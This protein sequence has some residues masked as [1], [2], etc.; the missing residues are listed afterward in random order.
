MTLRAVLVLVVAGCLAAAPAGAGSQPVRA[1]EGMVVAQ[2]AR[3][4]Q[5]GADVLRDGG[6]AV[7][8]AVATAFALA[9]T[10]PAA[11]NVGGGGF[12]LYRP[13]AG[14]PAAYDFREKAPAGATATMFLKDGRYDAERHHESHLSVG[15]PGT[16]AGLHMAW[17]EHGRLP[18]RRL[19]E[20][21]VA[22]ARDGFAVTDG[23][24]R[25]LKDV[26]PKMKKYPASVAQ[27][28][29]DGSPYAMGD[30]LKQPDLALTLERIA[31]R[32]P[33]GFYEGETAELVEKEMAAHG[34]LITR[35]DLRAY[36]A[37]RRDPLKG[38]YRGY[39]V[40]SMP[41][42][43]SGGTALIEM[44][45]V[46]EGYD[47]ARTGYGSA[48]TVHLL[49]EAMR[50][51]FA[52]RA[53][54][55]GDP[56]ANPQMPIDRLISKEYAATLRRTIHEDRAS[57]S[58]PE[59][60]EWP[61][62][63]AET[64]HVSVVDR[65]RNA[66]ALTYTLEDGYGSKI[67]V[68]GAGFLLN[69][70]MGDFN[71][72]PGLTDKDGLIGTEP[73]LAAPGKR[74]LSS[75]TPTIVARDGGL[76]M[77]VGT[78]GGRTIINT[79]LQALVNVID[80]GMNIQEAIDAPRL[81]HQWLPDRIQHERFGLSPDTRALLQAR[82]HTLFEAPFNQ[83]AA[84]GIVVNS[85]EGVLEGGYD[86]RSSESAAIGSAVEVRSALLAARP[87]VER[88]IQA[89]GAEV[90][91]AARALD[92]G[93]ALLIR[94]DDTFHAASTMKVPVMIELFAQAGQGRLRLDD[95][96]PVHNAFASIVDG[97]PYALDPAEDSD[98]EVYRAVGGSLTLRQLCEAMITVS[99]NLATNLLIEK[100]GV[101]NV[102]RRVRELGATGMNVLRGVE[103][104]K[105][106]RAGLVN[107]TTARGL[108][109]LLEAI[110]TDRAAG[111]EAGRE[112]VD[113]LKRQRF[114]AAIPAGLP[115][116]TPVA[117]KTGTITKIHHDAAIVYAARPYVLVVLVR[118]IAEEK[119][120]AAL[121]AGITRIV[122]EAIG[123][124]ERK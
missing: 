103:D 74:M 88:L 94:P 11:G 50:R 76:F 49:A 29:R 71:A 9:V 70:E 89:S 75:M 6:S 24:A 12:L 106:F 104:G 107:T 35:A 23:L 8:A 92:G 47:L 60:F 81:H 19:V 51:A 80:F 38:T 68:P 62:E 85:K 109:V 33:A 44:L 43:S 112:M 20:P 13:A 63:S 115:P 5:V 119:E 58:S 93:E 69:N 25:S 59:S 39:D 57:V 114:G 52:D 37:R 46:L 113:I 45:N 27:F 15:V 100:L 31:A 28:S 34:G 3:A 65:D 78:P 10:H 105:A 72:G 42:V 120:S 67:V 91:V 122:H 61:A 84:Q 17:R 101:E 1:R 14:A 97:S 111:P 16:V 55:L 22:L 96:L 26:L 18:W 99:S 124:R 98:R 118:G 48:A 79:V 30:T 87:E 83:G 32:G 86:R 108:L 7:D 4:A 95:P 121:I 82:G 2:E 116:G 77:V 117:H 54:H 56:D 90:A 66:V 123:G 40:L 64:T 36:E 41:P 21:A 110:A 102:R 53:R 73:N